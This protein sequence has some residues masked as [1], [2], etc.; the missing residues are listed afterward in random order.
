MRVFLC[1]AAAG[2]A[3]LVLQ[4]LLGVLGVHHRH[5]GGH[6]VSH[7]HGGRLGGRAGGR[8]GGRH[9]AK[10][11]RTR[12]GSYLT[13]LQ[14][15]AAAFAFFGLGGAA[16]LSSGAAVWSAV[17]VGAVAGVAAASGV[18]AL[19]RSMTA[20]ES[21]GTLPIDAAIGALGQVYVSIPARQAGRGKVHVTVR[22]RL[23]EYEATT[24]GEALAAGV[25]VLVTDIDGTDALVVCAV[26]E[27]LLQGN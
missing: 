24:N 10:M 7:H 12:W 15:I 27:P 5:H 2:G 3:F 17:T 6:H 19:L 22:D 21:D 9:G 13:N 11:A 18:A 23:V 8:A 16:V 4:F 25:S 20:F 1:C 26:D 14:S